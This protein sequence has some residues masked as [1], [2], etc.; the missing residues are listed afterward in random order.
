MQLGLARAVATHG[1]QVHAG[2]E[3]VGGDDGGVGLVGGHRGDDVH[4]FYRFCHRA[5]AAD[6]QAAVFLEVGDQ[7][8]GG[9]RVGVVGD[10]FFDAQVLVEGQCLEFALRTVADQ[11]HLARVRPGQRLRCHQ[12]GGRSA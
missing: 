8:G 9:Q 1:I 10:D 7:L 11:R 4:A 2:F 6:G 12:R 5:G 3:H